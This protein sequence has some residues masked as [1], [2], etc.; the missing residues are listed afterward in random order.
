MGFT[1]Y[2]E[3]IELT[4]L[5]HFRKALQF[6]RGPD[7][8][9][10]DEFNIM[11]EQDAKDKKK[12]AEEETN[13]KTTAKKIGSPTFLK[14]Y[15]IIGVLYVLLNLAGWNVITSYMVEILGKSGSIVPKEDVPPIYGNTAL[16]IAGK[17]TFV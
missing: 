6:Y 3:F 1:N 14:P 8:N 13:W 9:I 16:V 7:F 12:A 15:S 17:E 5:S 11:V 10:D 4:G 2:F